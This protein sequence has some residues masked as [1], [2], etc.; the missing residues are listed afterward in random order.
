MDIQ[1][2]SHSAFAGVQ[3]QSHPALIQGIYLG[4]GLERLSIERLT[5]KMSVGPIWKVNGVCSD[6]T[7]LVRLSSNIM[8]IYSA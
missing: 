5:I 7:I 2:L 4:I 1:Q 8:F 6:N 3:V